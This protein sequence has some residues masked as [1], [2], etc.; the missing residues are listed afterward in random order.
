[1]KIFDQWGHSK[2]DL[3]PSFE[4]L[5]LYHINVR[6]Y[7]L[8]KLHLR[9]DLT[10]RQFLRIAFFHEAPTNTSACRLSGHE[11]QSHFIAHTNT[12][13]INIMFFS[14]IYYYIF[15]CTS[16]LIVMWAMWERGGGGGGRKGRERGGGGRTP[17]RLPLSKAPDAVLL[18]NMTA[19]YGV[20]QTWTSLFNHMKEKNIK[21]DICGRSRPSSSPTGTG[22]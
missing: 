14:S 6:L 1:M 9:Q 2:A 19:L 20:R 22:V 7:R 10:V 17:S 15:I 11:H 4:F 16:V 12:E 3:L 18:E 13:A 21:W 5:C 8:S